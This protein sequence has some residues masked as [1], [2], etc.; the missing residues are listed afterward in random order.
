MLE[1]LR[2]QFIN[3]KAT[4]CSTLVSFKGV[5]NQHLSNDRIF[6]S[7]EGTYVQMCK[8][9]VYDV[10]SKLFIAHYIRIQRM[11]LIC[12]ILSIVYSYRNS[13]FFPNETR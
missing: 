4:L 3:S 5:N 12:V 13:E 1:K 2:R 9:K 6:I 11:L 7:I 10:L 8:N